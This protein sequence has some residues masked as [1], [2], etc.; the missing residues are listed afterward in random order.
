VD[1][2]SNA[3]ENENYFL[4]SFDPVRGS[5][6]VPVIGEVTKE[7]QLDRRISVTGREMIVEALNPYH[8][9]IITAAAQLDITAACK[10]SPLAP[11]YSPPDVTVSSRQHFPVPSGIG[12]RGGMARPVCADPARSQGRQEGF[13]ALQ[14][15]ERVL[16][17][18]KQIGHTRDG[19]GQRAQFDL[20]LQR[21][22]AHDFKVIGLVK[23]LAIAIPSQHIITRA[24][25][26]DV[27]SRA[28]RQE[29]GAGAAEE[30][31]SPVNGSTPGLFRGH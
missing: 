31:N 21:A 8:G 24:A 5:L 27:F 6:Q 28:A 13:A 29:V 4:A 9:G 16:G 19:G 17:F 2:F 14:L 10:P 22:Q 15:T 20:H 12:R 23:G 25:G 18:Q 11:E 3:V 26:Q 1:R 30:S 7:G